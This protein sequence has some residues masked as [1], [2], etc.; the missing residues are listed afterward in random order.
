MHNRRSRSLSRTALAL[1]ALATLVGCQTPKHSNVLIFGTNTRAGLSVGYDPKLQNGS[2]L[3]GYDRQEAVWMPLLANTNAQGDAPAIPDKGTVQDSLFI[4]K[5]GEATDTYSVIASIGAEFNAE[6]TTAASAGGGLAQFFATGLAARSL[7][8]RGAADLLSV[9]SESGAKARQ[10]E[11]E[12]RQAEIRQT[13]Q[14]LSNQRASDD[15]VRQKF[16]A[17]LATATDAQVAQLVTDAQAA[18]LI[19]EGRPVDTPANQRATL[20]V[21]LKAYDDAQRLQKLTALAAQYKL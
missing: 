12:A 8:E 19:P 16:T 17:Y 3:L 20:R 2:I 7:A 11:A 5:N 9:P 18:G 13:E 4:G 15:T 6:A 10:A 14:A 1:A 21:G